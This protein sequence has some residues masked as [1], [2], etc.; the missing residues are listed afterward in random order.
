[1]L[2]HNLPEWK[3]VEVGDLSAEDQVLW[4][5]LH[6]NGCPGIVSGY[7]DGSKRL[8]YAIVLIKRSGNTLRETLVVA[9]ED[10]ASA[11]LWV[12]SKARETVSP[13]VV[14]EDAPGKYRSSDGSREIRSR[15]PV[16]QYAKLEAGAILYYWKSG[17][18]RSILYS[19]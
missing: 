16:F 11:K 12:L 13:S 17:H 8:S 15:L 19:E 2:D 9:R 7:F 1:V 14:V 18:F 4:A 10:G 5:H 6:P 3:V